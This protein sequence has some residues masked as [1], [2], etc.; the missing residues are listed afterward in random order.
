[1]YNQFDTI[2]KNLLFKEL[3]IDNYL[4][5]NINTF[6]S[7]GGIPR[8]H[9]LGSIKLLEEIYSMNPLK[10]NPEDLEIL[11]NCYTDFDKF[12]IPFIDFYNTV[13]NVNFIKKI[14]EDI[15]KVVEDKGVKIIEDLNKDLLIY[16]QTYGII[17]NILKLIKYSKC[18]LNLKNPNLV[19]IY[20]L[21]NTTL[22]KTDLLFYLINK[23]IINLLCIDDYQL[24]NKQEKVIQYQ[25]VLLIIF[26]K[27]DFNKH[28]NDFL[29]TIKEFNE[30]HECINIPDEFFKE[31]ILEIDTYIN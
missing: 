9:R 2:S 18:L 30:K 28:I 12:F 7:A 13:T 15:E 27:L 29:R 20:L 6:S 25:K 3:E 16:T 31:K 26:D 23:Y 14:N 17:V 1:M 19:R 22:L 8:Y 24:A 5:A 4:K 10:F 11:F 21:K